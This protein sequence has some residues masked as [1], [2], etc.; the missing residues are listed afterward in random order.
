MAAEDR[1]PAQHLI[2][3]AAAGERVRSSGLFPLVRGRRSASAVSAARREVQ[4]ARPE[5]GRLEAC[6]DLCLPRL[7]SGVC[8]GRCGA[9]ESERLLVRSDRAH[10]AAAGASDRICRLR[11][12]I[13]QDPAVRRLSRPAR[14]ANAAAL[15]PQL[16]RIPSRPRTPT[17]HKTTSLHSISRPCP[18]RP[19][20]SPPMPS[21]RRARGCTMPACLPAGVALRRWRTH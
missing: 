12:Q 17:A 7:D 21:S 14:R 4:K 18:A 20:A 3:L 6:P 16:G 13:R 2:F 15:L 19:K 10:G 1:A 5:R 9:G 8:R 11:A